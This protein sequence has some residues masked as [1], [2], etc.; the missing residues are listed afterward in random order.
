MTRLTYRLALL[1]V[2]AALLAS[3]APLPGQV[4]MYAPPMTVSP[5]GK[6]IITAQGNQISVSDA[7]TQKELIRML[8]HTATIKALAVSPDGKILASGAEDKSI[9]LWELS[10]GKQVRKFLGPS[11]VIGLS[12]SP[13]GRNLIAQH[14]DQITNVWD[15]ATGQLIQSSKK[16]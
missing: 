8:G 9:A 14:V 15:I 16:Q 10:T 5:D 3:T 11:A 4:R 7:A 13:D 2:L 6:L 12:F 1:A